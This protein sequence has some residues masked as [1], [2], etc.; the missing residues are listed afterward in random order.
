MIRLLVVLAL[1]PNFL[2]GVLHESQAAPLVNTLGESSAMVDGVVNIISGSLVLYEKDL[3]VEGPE[4]VVFSRVYDS[5][6]KIWGN[7]GRWRHNLRSDLEYTCEKNRSYSCAYRQEQGSV[8]WLSGKHADSSMQT[9]NFDSSSVR[10]Q[11]ITNSATGL[12]SG[13]T[14]LHN[15]SS[16]I[17][18]EAATSYWMYLGSGEAKEFTPLKRTRRYTQYLQT[19]IRKPSGNHQYFNFEGDL[20]THVVSKNEMGDVEFGD[21]K[22]YKSHIT[23]TLLRPHEL[24]YDV[25]ASDGRKVHYGFTKVFRSRHTSSLCLTSV[26]SDFSPE[27]KLEYILNHK[28]QEAFLSARRLPENRYLGIKY[29]YYGVNG[30]F[31]DRIIDFGEK[32]LIGK[33]HGLT[34][35][36]GVDA[37]PVMTRAF[38]YWNNQNGSG[39]ARTWDAHGNETAYHYDEKKRLK[40]VFRLDHYDDPLENYKK[41]V[42]Q[43]D[44]FTWSNEKSSNG[45]LLSHR[46]C[47]GDQ[48]TVVEKS[49][50][51]DERGNVLEEKLTGSITGDGVSDYTKHFEYTDDGYNLPIFESDGRAKTRLTYKLNTNLLTSKITSNQEETLFQREFYQYDKNGVCVETIKDDGS[52][53]SSEDLTNITQ[54][55]ITRITPKEE[56]PCIGLPIVEEAYFLDLETGEEVLLSKVIKSY[57][58]LGLKESEEV[59]DADGEL[60]F[61]RSWI[62]DK[63]GN[64]TSETDPLGHRI[65]REFDANGNLISER[66]V[67]A[68]TFKNFTYDFSNRLVKQTEL[69]G[70]DVIVKH[71]RYN[72]LSQKVSE[73]DTF[74]NETEYEYDILGRMIKRVLPEVA[75]EAGVSVRPVELYEYDLLGNVT[76]ITDALG[77]QT[78]SESNIYGKPFRV[79][80]PDQSFE[81]ST[82]LDNGW[83]AEKKTRKGSIFK[84]IYDDFGRVIKEELYSEDDNLLF[85]KTNKYNAYHLLRS[86]DARGITT[87]YKYDGAGRK[88][89]QLRGSQKI[90]YEY[91][92]LGRLY[93]TIHHLDN[94]EKVDI[95]EFNVLDQVIEE[96]VEN[97]D[98]LVLQKTTY[99]YDKMGNRNT[100]IQYTEEGI[101]VTRTEYDCLKRPIKIIDAEGNETH[102]IYHYDLGQGLSVEIIDPLGRRKISSYDALNHLVS[103]QKLDPYGDL[104]SEERCFYDLRGK[105]KAIE[106]DVI[107]NHEVES[108]QRYEWEY[109]TMGKVLA[110]YIAVG[111]EDQAIT[112][113]QYT[114]FGEKEQEVKPSGHTLHFTYDARGLL[115]TFS[116]RGN[117]FSYVYQ[118]DENK[119]LLRVDDLFLE[120]STLRKYNQDD[121]LI[122]EIQGNGL[123]ISHQ[124][125]ATGRPTELIY[126]DGKS[127]R[128]HY[129]P[130]FLRKIC[131]DGFEHRYDNFDLSGHCLAE[132]TISGHSISR[133]YNFLGQLTSQ[134]T[135]EREQKSFQYDETGRLL[136]YSLKDPLGE[137][138]NR[139][140]YDDLDQLISEEG[141][142]HHIYK[143]DSINNRRDKDGKVNHVNARNQLLSDGE[144][145]Y[146]YDLD[147][148]L[149][150]MEGN[151]EIT[152]RHD[153]LNRLTAVETSDSS[154]KYTYDSFNRRLD[155]KKYIDGVLVSTEKYFYS[156]QK[157]IGAWQKGKVTQRRILGHGKGAEI[158]ATVLI[159]IDGWAF[160]PYHDHN[161]NIATL[162]DSKGRMRECY[163]YSAFGEPEK[164]ISPKTGI[165]NK[166][167]DRKGP[168]GNPWR[169]S[170]KRLDPETGFIYFGMRYYSPKIGRWVTTDPKG[171]QAGPNYYAY[172][173][174]EPLL[175]IDLYGLETAWINSF[176]SFCF[177]KKPTAVSRVASSCQQAC[178]TGANFAWNALPNGAGKRL[179]YSSL[180]FFGGDGLRTT[181]RN[182]THST[183]FMRGS[184]HRYPNVLVSAGNGINTTYDDWWKTTGEISEMFGGEQ[185]FGMYNS[186]FGMCSDFGDVFLEKCF[187]RTDPVK[188][189]MA[190]FTIMDGLLTDKGIHIHIAHSEGALIAYMALQNLNESIR[191]KVALIT[192]GGAKM[193]PK[194]FAKL[195]KNFASEYDS[196]PPGADPWGYFVGTRNGTVEVEILKAN[197]F[198]IL[199]HSLNGDTYHGLLKRL[200]KAFLKGKFFKEDLREAGR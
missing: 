145:E 3:E 172:V 191:R 107:I 95:Q 147:G 102:T 174:N 15:L 14:N 59:F 187:V 54:R 66:G 113:Y 97:E 169:L 47:G 32:G 92:S 188:Q 29:Y 91:D 173:L 118:Y 76:S 6:D 128:Y 189:A 30:L 5:G 164:E 65:E 190:F 163:R 154:Y 87:T 60:A 24:N 127:A 98:G 28:A 81:M 176:G 137:L 126:P 165:I 140:I 130:A 181:P 152:L 69:C 122:E 161:G 89:E 78:T 72:H 120:R 86:T 58:N 56:A 151:K 162:T 68:N 25:I 155:K 149:I 131:W 38:W 85:T 18:A 44:Y 195:E 199:D 55:L 50:V 52:G 157:E 105:I 183:L 4:K 193:I 12:I 119:N 153:A 200:G 40:E 101:A 48:E 133:T 88:I 53:E 43:C 167:L 46:I 39:G 41:N 180:S 73:V 136:S 27:Q 62:Y 114:L 84:Y 36:V 182:F 179:A 93:K 22:L 57:S 64:C 2:L 16:K 42:L 1:F 75:D 148:N 138:T 198:S 170:S 33:V 99:D 110:E 141:V 144:S 121:R 158:G 31:G 112:R 146:S 185:V 104:L 79:T 45:N 186:T 20:Y 160:V 129:S 106:H 171:Y 142:S 123:K 177:G 61:R 159:E 134:I 94:S 192:I 74:G 77:Y 132:T 96:R 124:Y 34:A 178:R 103:M 166:F 21:L 184:G 11:G 8:L 71:F 100:L 82:Y 194:N 139:Y 51:Y 125:D 23:K 35:P 108:I 80:Y 156:G 70:D 17:D 49:Y 116:D 115:K 117:S 9:L 197:S 175:H 37:S 7:L 196:I 67:N 135:P 143:Y 109:N 10:N 63:M 90:S 168:T 83:L 111:T 150:Q 13:Q 26:K 19:H